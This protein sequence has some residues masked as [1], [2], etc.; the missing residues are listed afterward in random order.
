MAVNT[1][2]WSVP[3]FL[4]VPF[5]LLVPIRAWQHLCNRA[6]SAIAGFW[7]RGNTL[8]QQL[9]CTIN[10][11]VSSVENLSPKQWYMVLAN[12]QS[13]V[14]I[15]VLQKIFHKK[16]P[17][18]KFFIKKEL[19]WLPLLGQ[20]WWVMDFPFMKRYSKKLLARKPH[21]R[22]RDMEI[23]RKACEKFKSLPISVM[24]FVEGTRFSFEKHRKQAS[25][26]KNLLKTKAGGI[27][28]VLSTMGDQ[29]SRIL[30]VTIVYP[31]GKKSF[32]AYLCGKI[33]CINVRINAL[34][35]TDDL[36]GDYLNDNQF[37]ERIHG[38]LN[39]LWLEKDRR[40]E[41]MRNC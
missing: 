22:G 29:V 11:D 27:A 2:F 37:R 7:I 23:T 12:H 8:I 34:P 31:D 33:E 18:L 35:V 25:P 39:S 14:D 13:W 4:C 20:A 5:K 26:Y 28:F 41:F 24:N 30:D 21:L 17:F 19:I 1:V 16:I 36:R 15:L 6:L 32:W 10:W 40:I 3:I 9:S 38:W